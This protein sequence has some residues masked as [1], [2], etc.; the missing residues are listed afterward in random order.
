MHALSGS[1]IK[2]KDFEKL[3]ALIQGCVRMEERAWVDFVNSW[4]SMIS[5]VS[6]RIVANDHEELVQMVFMRLME[7]NAAVLSKFNG[8][9]TAFSVYLQRIVWN[10]SKSYFR[11]THRYG[12]KQCPDMETV[13]KAESKFKLPEECLVDN[14]WRNELFEALEKLD[15]RYSS[16]IALLVL[17]YKHREIAA[18]LDISLNACLSRSSRAKGMLR[19]MLQENGNPLTGKI[20]GIT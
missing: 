6:R 5:S 7:N 9:E 16:V 15:T 14:E 10:V 20:D 4:G 19:K 11:S 17:G 1:A 13:L 8:G 3:Q 18:I 12:S 2:E